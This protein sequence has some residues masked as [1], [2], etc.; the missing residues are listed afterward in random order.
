MTFEGCKVQKKRTKLKGV[1]VSLMAYSAVGLDMFSYMEVGTHYRRHYSD[2]RRVIL[3]GPEDGGYLMWKCLFSVA[4][5]VR[6]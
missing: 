6:L 5:C 1:N 3:T 2:W 4:A